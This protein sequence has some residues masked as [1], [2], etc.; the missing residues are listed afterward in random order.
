MQ[1]DPQYVT[2]I[3]P[4]PHNHTTNSV[5]SHYSWVKQGIKVTLKLHDMPNPNKDFSSMMMINGRST[6]A[7]K[8]N[9][10]NKTPLLPLNHFI[11]IDPI[12]YN[13]NNN[14]NVRSTSTRFTSYNESTPPLPKLSVGSSLPTPPTQ[15]TSRN[16]PSDIFFRKTH[17]NLQ[18]ISLTLIYP[19]QPCQNH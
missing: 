12:S 13:T 4:D 17:W 10:E 9:Q 3:S 18:I 11:N 19:L 5:V 16:L 1:V 2:N 14:C 7:K 15:P 8:N 6:Q